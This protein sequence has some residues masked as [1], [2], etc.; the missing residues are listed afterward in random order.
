MAVEG[1]TARSQPARRRLRRGRA[2]GNDARGRLSEESAGSQGESAGSQG[3][4]ADSRWGSAGSQGGQNRNWGAGELLPV[5]EGEVGEARE[6]AEV[7]G[8]QGAVVNDGG[9]ADEQVE[10][11]DRMAGLLKAD[12]FTGGQF[13]GGR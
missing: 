9:A 10:V 7:V 13:I 11:F 6:V 1:G 8:Y 3:E 2:G 5:G 4:S 12:L